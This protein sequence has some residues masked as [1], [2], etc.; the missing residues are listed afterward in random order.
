[1]TSPYTTFEIIISKKSIK[2]LKDQGRAIELKILD[3]IKMLLNDNYKNLDIKK[4]KGYANLY[5]IKV[6]NYRIVYQPDL[7]NKNI[8]VVAEHRKNIYSL[9]NRQT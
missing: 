1:M 5:R 3:K 6:G 8:K 7:K 9:I 4:L 2:W